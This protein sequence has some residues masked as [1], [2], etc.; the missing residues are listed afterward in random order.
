MP[1]RLLHEAAG[2]RT[3][4][5][6]LATGDEVLQSLQKFVERENIHAAQFSAIGA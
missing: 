4:V 5:V 2:Q 3:Y 6:V 1:Y